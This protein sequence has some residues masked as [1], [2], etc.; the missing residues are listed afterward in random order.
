[1]KPNLRL[2]T[3]I[4]ASVILVCLVGLLLFRKGTD[5]GTAFKFP[6]GVTDVRANLRDRINLGLDLRGGMHL[7]LQVQVDEAV[8]AETD[9]LAERLQTLL[10]EQ[11]IDFQSVRK[12]DPQH[13]Q[14]LGIPPTQLATARAYL[15]DTY[16]TRGAFGAAGYIIGSLAGEQSGY[17]LEMTPSMAAQIRQDT[18]RSSIE[19]I[20][21]RVDELGV[22]EP[23]IAEHGR[24]EWEILVQLPGVDDPNRV[25][26]ILQSTALLEIKLV[27]GGPHAS[28][29]AVR[30][31]PGATFA[32]PAPKSTRRFPEPTRSPSV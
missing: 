30:R 23:T 7:I 27:K 18:V 8:N 25:K 32:P 26:N 5:G 1:M 6:T 11:A 9:Q 16:Q 29:P 15:E 19:T 21:Q 20:R 14:V 28:G 17:V 3:T 4:I 24:G 13:V 2:K 22:S 12:A 31:S 10:R